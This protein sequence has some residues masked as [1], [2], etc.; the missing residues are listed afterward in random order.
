MLECV[1]YLVHKENGTDALGQRLSQHGL[2]L[3]AHAL[4]SVDHHYCAISHSQGRGNLSAEMYDISFCI[5]ISKEK[6]PV[7]EVYVTR[8]VDEIDYARRRCGGFRVRY[9]KVHGHAG[10]LD[11]DA[12][13]F[14]L[15]AGL[16][17]ALLRC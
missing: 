10:S 3:H 11:G 16:G 7:P 14:L 6:E 15:R 9:F 2:G 1:F 4:D 17:E 13:S 8:A 12:S 5:S